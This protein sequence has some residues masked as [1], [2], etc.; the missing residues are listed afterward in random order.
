MTGIRDKT[1][2]RSL[3]VSGCLDSARSLPKRNGIRSPWVAEIPDFPGVL[4]VPDEARAKSPK[5]I[6]F[7]HLTIIIEMIASYYATVI[8]LLFCPFA[9]IKY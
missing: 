6:R 2:F 1:A 4:F 7:R 5:N 3:T 9:Y 8:T